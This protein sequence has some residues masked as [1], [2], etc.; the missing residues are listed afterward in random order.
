MLRE[1]LNGILQGRVE[2]PDEIALNSVWI[3]QASKLL[4]G[5]L[6]ASYFLMSEQTS[7]LRACT[8]SVLLR[9][10]FLFGAACLSRAV[11][12]AQTG[13]LTP[14]ADHDVHRVGT[15]P[16]PAAPPALP[17]EE[18][19]KRF[20]QK[21]DVYLAA[22]AGYTYK[23]T[24]RLQEFG[25]DGQPA[26]Q[27]S[28]VIEAKPGADG[29]VYEKT[30]ERPQ[31][32]LQY[33]EMG[34]EDFQKLARMPAYPLITAQLSK[35]DL[36]YLGKELVDEID[37]YIF[38]AK[39]RAVERAH[40]FFDGIIWVDTQYLEVVKT[41]GKWVNDLGDMRTDTMPFSIFETYRENVD[42][43]LWL[44]N[45]MRSDDTLNLKGRNVPVRLVVKWTEYK[46]I[47]ATTPA[48]A[49]AAPAPAAA[50]PAPADKPQR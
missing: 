39:P 7:H 38:Q 10:V 37:C 1:E 47:S 42:G 46:P 14:P 33:L 28:V 23:K 5:A 6:S 24:V 31:S 13:P 21:E 43:K 32:T 41:Y 26:G 19:I 18:I 35:Y 12:Y 15:E 48:P 22:R 17:P 20:S 16:V 9:S 27:L 34:P 3:A 45:Y 49:A 29:K 40:Y 2:P 8:S 44:P 50:Q 30:V 4:F 36:K 25:P 11:C